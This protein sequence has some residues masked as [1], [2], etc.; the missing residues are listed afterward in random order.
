MPTTFD[1]EGRRF[2]FRV[3]CVALRNGQVLLHQPVGAGY[4]TLPGGRPE[5][6]EGSRNALIRELHEELHTEA[7][8]DRLLWIVEAFFDFE[9]TAW[10]E[11]SLVFLCRL[12]PDSA[13]MVATKPFEDFEG[14]Q[15]LL[16]DWVALDEL[17]QRTVYPKFLAA[18]LRTL[19]TAT[20][21]VVEGDSG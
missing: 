3:A 13:A 4:W 17:P 9:G 1:V 10:H 16:F 12:P 14:G 6:G 20:L 5:L 21:H 2:S 11:V 19:P 7:E 18:G 15:R 8:V